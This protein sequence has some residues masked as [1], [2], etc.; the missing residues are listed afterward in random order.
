[1]GR[2]G[3]ATQL[4]EARVIRSGET[5]QRLAVTGDGARL[6]RSTPDRRLDKLGQFQRIHR[7][8]LDRIDK[9]NRIFIRSNI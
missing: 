5:D 8:F 3:D 6:R 9:I 2:F 4:S 7:F 1:V